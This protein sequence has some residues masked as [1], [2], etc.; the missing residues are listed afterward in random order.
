VDNEMQ[1][2]ADDK[3]LS[4]YCGKKGWTWRH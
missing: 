4:K 1:F 2:I 3:T